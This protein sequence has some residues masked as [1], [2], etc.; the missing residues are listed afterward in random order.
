MLWIW[1]H[2]WHNIFFLLKNANINFSLH[3]TQHFSVCGEM[4]RTC[5][6]THSENFTFILWK[7]S[8]ELF[9]CGNDN[10]P[11]YSKIWKYVSQTDYEFLKRHNGSSSDSIFSLSFFWTGLKRPREALA[12]YCY[13]LSRLSD[14]ILF[15]FCWDINLVIARKSLTIKR[16]CS[17]IYVQPLGVEHFHIKVVNVFLFLF[18]PPPIPYSLSVREEKWWKTKDIEGKRT[19]KWI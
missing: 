5:C 19:R 10:L 3:F 7:V 11:S 14:I 17:L 6:N 16:Y 9:K 1:K 13:D 2:F 15:R 8:K 4:S 12:F 18:F